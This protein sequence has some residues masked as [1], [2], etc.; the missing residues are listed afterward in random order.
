MLEKLAKLSYFHLVLFY[1]L[2][3]AKIPFHH[4]LTFSVVYIY[5]ILNKSLV[6]SKLTAMYFETKDVASGDSVLFAPRLPVDYAVWLGEIKPASY[7]KV[8]Y[9]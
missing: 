6:K 7:F 2:R 3:C 8:L 9:S 1:S 5:L 4:E